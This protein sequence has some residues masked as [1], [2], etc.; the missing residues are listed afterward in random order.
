MNIVIV[1]AGKAG[2]LHF[3]SYYKLYKI[4]LV[5]LN[6]IFFVDTNGSLGPDIFKLINIIARSYK[7]Y[8]SF[9]SL[10]NEEQLIPE[11]TIIDLCIPSGTFIKTMQMIN[12]YGFS[13][14][15]V[16]KP[17][18]I[19]DEST[20]SNHLTEFLRK[21][22]IIK[23]ENYLHSKVHKIIKHLIN[24]YNLEVSAVVTNF[25]KD[26]QAESLRGRAF[27]LGQAPPSVFEIEVPHQI[28]ICNDLFGDID[29]LI[30]VYSKDMIVE[31]N[32]IKKHGEGL[33][34]GKNPENALYIHYSNLCFNR[35]YRT[36]DIFFKNNYYLHGI[37]APVC[38]DELGVKAGV[39]LSNDSKVIE[40]C[41]FDD[42]DN[43]L[44]MITYAFICFQNGCYDKYASPSQ[45]WNFSNLMKNV[46]DFETQNSNLH[47]FDYQNS[48]FNV[49]QLWLLQ[50]FIP[51]NLEPNHK[52]L[53]FLEDIKFKYFK[54]KK[55]NLVTS[56]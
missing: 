56:K 17:F 48:N 21:L 41:F 30:Y 46:L 52:F 45:I 28:Y 47:S 34:V 36:I 13:N 1:G 15:L 37:Y 27:G 8:K 40:S 39:V 43:M 20:E 24:K 32:I 42:D 6:R 14:F 7:V 10:L 4:G 35:V 53:S 54:N 50:M 38:E 19:S 44:D 22:K 26:R 18:V 11:N 5:D 29:E 49:M 2:F 12:K 51:T 25:S 23:I 3:T 33:V 31:G 16:E 55:R 9:D